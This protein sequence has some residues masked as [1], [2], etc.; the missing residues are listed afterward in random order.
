MLKIS[1]ALIAFVVHTAAAAQATPIGLWK[2]IDDETKKEKSLVR[3]AETGGVLS[4]SIE[5]VLD[6]AKEKDVCEKCSDERKGK[7]I[8]GLNIIRNAKPDGDDKSSWTG[9][10]ILDPNNGKTYR[11]R[12]KPH[13]G[14]KTL[15]VRGYIGPFF[16][17]Q[18]WIRVE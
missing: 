18:T 12:L 3:I 16:R 1:L 7:P 6:P 4:G 8:V 2:T 9:G 10:E 17:N 11:L 14:G 5:K 13:D 15:E